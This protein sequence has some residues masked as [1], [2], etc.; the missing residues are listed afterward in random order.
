MTM[1]TISNLVESVA[2]EAGRS[3]TTRGSSRGDAASATAAPERVFAVN[4]VSLEVGDGEMFTLLGPSGCGKATTLRA[5]AGLERPDSR[6]IVVGGHTLFDGDA[7]LDVP[8][9][10]RGLGMVFQSYAI[11]QH[12]TVFDNVAY[13]LSGGQQRRALA[14]RAASGSG[15]TRQSPSRRERTSSLRGNRARSRSARPAG[16]SG[17]TPPQKGHTEG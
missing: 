8:A 17:S 7:G 16:A 2:G 13:T 6:R 11:W 1:L 4:D 5:V 10:Q 15:A 12:M 14:A 9:N 3:R